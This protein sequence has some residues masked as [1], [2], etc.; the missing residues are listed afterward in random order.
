MLWSS[1]PLHEDCPVWDVSVFFTIPAV[2]PVK[3]RGGANAVAKDSLHSLELSP[4]MK[5]KFLD[6]IRSNPR[7]VSPGVKPVPR[8]LMG[9]IKALLQANKS[10]IWVSRFLMEFKVRGEGEMEA[11]ERRVEGKKEGGRGKKEG[12]GGKKEG[13]RRRGGITEGNGVGE[14]G[15]I[16]R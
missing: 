2:S 15:S 13:G 10:G 3:S 9:Q 14:G 12:G 8:P 11:G 7:S 16:L 1:R 6:D 4:Q 5:K